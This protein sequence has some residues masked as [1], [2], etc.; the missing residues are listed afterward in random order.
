MMLVWANLAVASPFTEAVAEA[1]AGALGAEEVR[2]A[3]PV[4]T[5]W[6]RVDLGAEWRAFLSPGGER[7]LAQLAE[8]AGL[9]GMGGTPAGLLGRWEA[10][11]GARRAADLAPLRARW[12]QLIFATHAPLGGSHYAYTEALSDAQAERNFVPGGGLY[13]LDVR[14]GGVTPLFETSEGQVRDADVSFDGQRVLY[15]YKASDRGDDYHL[16]ELDLVTGERRQIT[17]GLGV[18]DYEGVYLPSGDLLFNST[19]CQQ[20][21]DCWW[22]EVSNLYTC[23]PDGSGLRRLTY[24]QVHDN[25]P[26]LLDD[27]RLVYT[28]WDYND[29]GQIFPQGLFSMWPDGSGQSAFYGNNSWFPTTLIHARGIPGTNRL[30][31]IATGHHSYQPGELVRIDP[32]AGREEN[33]GVQLLA[34]VRET[35]AERID[36]YGQQGPMFAYPY[37]LSDDEFLISYLPEGWRPGVHPGHETGF[38]LY[39]M[40]ADGRRELLAQD[41]RQSI[42]RMVPLVPRDTPRPVASRLDARRADG[43]LYMQDI[44]QGPGLAG[45]PRGSVAALRVIGLEWRA[46]GVGSNFNGGPAGGALVSTPP[47][48]SHGTWDVKHVLGT[49]PVEA[50]GS[51]WVR[52]PARMPLYLQ[53]LDEQGQALATMRSWTTLMPG[54]TQS[55]VGCHESPNT[56]P[57]NQGRSLATI[58][59]EREL[60]PFYGPARG[61]SF[62]QEIQPILDRQCVSCHTDSDLSAPGSRAGAPTPGPDR[63]AFSLRGHPVPD[64]QAK[65]FWSESYLALTA[66]ARDG[67]TGGWTGQSGIVANWLNVQS[68]PSMLPPAQAGAVASPLLAMLDAG[69]EGVRLTREEREK[70]ACWIDLLVPFCGDYAEAANWTP[71][72]H[73]RYQGWLDKRARLAALEEYAG[74]EGAGADH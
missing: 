6:L 64:P 36:A 71:E 3:R 70:I 41:V 52:V 7:F 55:C 32:S 18:A 67:E 26:T 11:R 56:V 57:P 4:E 5:D 9:P 24:D 10:A 20:I 23:R 19:R 50:D 44:Y 16:W 39:W 2:A 60:E 58:A 46:A 1:W 53:A 45:L 43:A 25:Y 42:G 40:R 59:G 61:F 37:P 72:E 28:R 29:R 17:F 49:T 34:P 8:A 69:H 65:R 38:G 30:L 33:L 21:V 14:T 13:R 68:E 54:E 47:A 73:A 63:R 66:S 35:P 31:A 22:T 12:P 62:A 27:G 48:I 15:S 74:G 51:A